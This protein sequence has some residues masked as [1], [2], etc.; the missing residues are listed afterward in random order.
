MCAHL[1][2]RKWAKQ[3]RKVLIKWIVSNKNQIKILEQA[4]NQ[5]KA[6]YENLSFFL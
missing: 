3:H 6:N 4:E 2:T 5:W 1:A